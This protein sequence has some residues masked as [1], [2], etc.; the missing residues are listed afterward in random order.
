M[1]LRHYKTWF[2]Y[3]FRHRMHSI[4]F[5]QSDRGRFCMHLRRINSLCSVEAAITALRA[6]TSRLMEC[7]GHT[8]ADC[9]IKRLECLWGQMC[10]QARETS[11]DWLIGWKRKQEKGQRPLHHKASM[12]RCQT[13]R[14]RETWLSI[15]L[16]LQ[17]L[18]ADNS[19]G[20]EASFTVQRLQGWHLQVHPEEISGCLLLHF[21][22]L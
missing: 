8:H 12:E 11:K 21:A 19:K 16:I 5:P 6:E 4:K 17:T 9:C 10:L 22:A 3:S 2:I 7:R 20:S 18:S 13:L 1:C 14:Q 15:R